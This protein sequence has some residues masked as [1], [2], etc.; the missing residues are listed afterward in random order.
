MIYANTASL[1]S[2]AMA[3]REGIMTQDES[4]CR[5]DVDS[6]ATSVAVQSTGSIENLTPDLARMGGNKSI[7][8]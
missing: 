1:T 3:T 5:P 2:T 4:V 8:T 6:P 7:A